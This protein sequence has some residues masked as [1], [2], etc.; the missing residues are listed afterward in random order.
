MRWRRLVAMGKESGKPLWF[1]YIRAWQPS[2][3]TE[4]TDKTLTCLLLGRRWP[5]INCDSHMPPTGLY[6]RSHEPIVVW[7][8]SVP[9]W[10]R[11]QH[12]QI[13]EGRDLTA[14]KAFQ[15]PSR[16]KSGT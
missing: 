1:I 6:H 4:I 7:R 10:R 3:P 12:G 16:F 15:Q 11:R 13:L 14:R 8:R 2:P 5:N 9:G